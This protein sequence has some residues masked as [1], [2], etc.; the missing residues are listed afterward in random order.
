MLEVKI[1]KS[2]AQLILE[3]DKDGYLD[4]FINR[5]LNSSKYAG[6]DKL[7]SIYIDSKHRG[8]CERIKIKNHQFNHTT[9][10]Y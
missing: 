9:Q 7:F 8:L 5:D 2:D 10:D 6:R 1:S 4:G 3:A